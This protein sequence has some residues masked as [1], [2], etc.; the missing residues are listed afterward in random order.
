MWLPNTLVLGLKRMRLTF[1]DNNAWPSINRPS[2]NFCSDIF[3]APELIDPSSSQPRLQKLLSTISL[4][5]SHSEAKTAPSEKRLN[6]VDRAFKSADSFVNHA[7]GL[8]AKPQLEDLLVAVAEIPPCKLLLPRLDGGHDSLTHLSRLH[9]DLC[10][11]C[12]GFAR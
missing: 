12:T 6:L 5:H 11:R 7:S 8:N 2:D 10:H 3:P 9:T 1:S 4:M